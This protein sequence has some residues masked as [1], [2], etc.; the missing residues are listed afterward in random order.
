MRL[1]VVFLAAVAV[2]PVGGCRPTVDTD[3]L[4]H[5]PKHEEQLARLCAR[6]LDDAVTRAFC[7]DSPPVIDSLATLQRVLDV[8]PTEGTSRTA[9][10]LTGHSSALF[11]RSVSGP[12]PRAIFVKFPN[13]RADEN[14][15]TLGF[16]RGEQVVEIGV[17]P[18]GGEPT[19]YLLRYEQPCSTAGDDGGSAC[20]I[21][22]TLAAGTE[23]G[24]TNTS[25]YVDSDLENSVFD[26]LH[27]HQP[28]GPG[29]PRMFRMQELQNPWT[30]WFAGF[31]AG[32]ALVEE[33][34]LF[35]DDADFAGIPNVQLTTSN[36]IV[37]QN[38][39]EI[40]Q[41]A[42]R[43]L[44]PSPVI[45][46]EVNASAPGQP[47]DHVVCGTSPTWQGLFDEAV[48]GRAIPVPFHDVK[49]TDPARVLDAA[50]AWRAFVADERRDPPDLRDLMREEAL[51]G[52]SAKALPGA[53][54][55]E[56]LVQ[57]CAQCHND[58]TDTDLSRARFNAFAL[59]DLDAAARETIIERLRLPAEDRYKMPP[60]F[61]RTLSDDEIDRIE[62]FLR[63]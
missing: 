48:A 16:S 7:G 2:S 33:Y 45:E 22:D 28:E 56:L 61:M 30:H 43:N 24:W 55:P 57:M 47:F 12:N 50:N 63:R 38:V 29:T 51:L 13:Q 41:S 23:T 62:A 8:H 27:C 20:T 4:S 59:D 14:I 1:V 3:P 18:P 9:F 15:V 5:L 10:A 52:T 25:L 58:S 39:V 21:K 31:S 19:F 42:Q 54:A 34:R 36:P 6:G 46:A 17:Q 11:G 26:C 37:V 32:R 35:H 44:F 49:V 40:S 60:S 53:S